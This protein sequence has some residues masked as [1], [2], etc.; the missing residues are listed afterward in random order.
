MSIL[1]DQENLVLAYLKRNKS[2][3]IDQIQKE[4][5]INR[6]ALLSVVESLLTRG[7]IT[8]K[9]ESREEATLTTEGNSYKSAFPEEDFVREIAASK[10]N[11]SLAGKNS[12]GLIWSKK[13]NWV[14]LDKGKVTRTEL[15]RDIVS[16]KKEYAQRTVLNKLAAGQSGN[17]SGAEKGVVRYFILQ[18]SG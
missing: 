17:L 16:G 3:T 18:E 7:S 15:G 6:D 10:G 13:N 5:G 14:T 12:L 4:T 9:R 1:N 11:I 8:L 2:A